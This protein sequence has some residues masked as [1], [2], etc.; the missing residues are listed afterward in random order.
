LRR[1]KV[2]QSTYVCTLR[3]IPTRAL[4]TEG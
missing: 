1:M 3:R 2:F 4:E